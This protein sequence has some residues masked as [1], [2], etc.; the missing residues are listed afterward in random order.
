MIDQSLCPPP[1]LDYGI[2]V[3]KF[4][5]IGEEYSRHCRELAG[6]TPDER[7]LDVGCGFAPLAAGLTTYLSPAGSYVGIDA[8]PNGVQWA[9]RTITPRFPNFQ[10]SWI[11]LYNQTYRPSGELDPRSFRFP[12]PDNE[13]DLVYLRSVF[14][15]MP[16]AE[17]DHYL[18]EVCRVLRLR[19]RCLITYFLLNDESIRLMSGDRSCIDF[20]YDNGVYRM[21]DPGPGG[22]FAYQEDHVLRLYRKHRL[23]LAGPIHY[24]TWC[25]R[26]SGRSS[27]DILVATKGEGL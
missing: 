7:V 25:G 18:S 19:G 21:H 24:G 9:D 15:H 6:L 26:T 20:A 3:D 12:F 14:T 8:V 11:D 17:V 1:E 4:C 2:R 22:S 10:F 27:Q 16:P 13:F 23:R 5:A